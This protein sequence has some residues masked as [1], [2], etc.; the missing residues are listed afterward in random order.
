MTLQEKG[1]FMV[2][3]LNR[4]S[5]EVPAPVAIGKMKKM[6]GYLSKGIPGGAGLRDRIHASR[7]PAELLDAVSDFLSHVP[8]PQCTETELT[9]IQLGLRRVLRPFLGISDWN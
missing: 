6:G 3:F 1:A 8:D 7:S 9:P 4:V 2:R 5:A